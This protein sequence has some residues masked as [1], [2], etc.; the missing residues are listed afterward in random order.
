MLTAIIL[1][2][3]GFF[4]GFMHLSVIFMYIRRKRNCMS[5]QL[6]LKWEERGPVTLTTVVAIAIGLILTG[7]ALSF[8]YIAGLGT[9]LGMIPF[10]VLVWFVVMWLIPNGARASYS[11]AQALSLWMAEQVDREDWQIETRTSLKQKVRDLTAERDQLRN[12]LPAIE[13]T[14]TAR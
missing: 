10:P 6:F 8:S 11:S 14:A 4:A 7:I 5:S 3:G 12:R 9:A 13:T 1:L 2:A